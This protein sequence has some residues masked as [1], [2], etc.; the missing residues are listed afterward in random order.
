MSLLLHLIKIILLY[1]IIKAP[2]NTQFS[3][4]IVWIRVV[5]LS[6]AAFKAWMKICSQIWKLEL[7]GSSRTT[8]N[9]SRSRA[10]SPPGSCSSSRTTDNPI[11]K[12]WFSGI[13]TNVSLP[14]W[15]K[16]AKIR[17]SC[18]TFSCCA[19]F[20]RYV[21]LFR[22]VCEVVWQVWHTFGQDLEIL[23]MPRNSRGIWDA[24][25]M[26]FFLCFYGRRHE[27][28]FTAKLKILCNNNR[29][30]CAFLHVAP[31]PFRPLSQVKCK[32]IRLKSHFMQGIVRMAEF[33]VE[34]GA[35]NLYLSTKHSDFPPLSMICC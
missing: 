7:T 22:H 28:A 17:S 14:E 30:Y 11:L 6:S 26:F 34:H 2:T 15:G 25:Q 20:E 13:K 31:T 9:P 5:F 23:Y 3:F 12:F 4:Y 10:Q 21:K 8:D 32:K 35:T 18:P 16:R 33:T 27:N 1:T 19:F 29:K 24:R